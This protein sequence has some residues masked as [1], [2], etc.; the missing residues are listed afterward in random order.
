MKILKIATITLSLAVAACDDAGNENAAFNA[1]PEVLNTTPYPEDMRSRFIANCLT[2]GGAEDRC[3]CVLSEMERTV[4]LEDVIA[5]A[6]Q[7]RDSGTVSSEYS[8]R[9]VEANVRC[10]LAKTDDG[11]TADPEASNAEEAPVP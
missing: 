4:P 5:A 8:E 11:V 10:A 1:E 7:V 3:A 2:N 6:R 9:M